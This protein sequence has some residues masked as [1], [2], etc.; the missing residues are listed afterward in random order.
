[1]IVRVVVA[2]NSYNGPDL[3]FCKIQCTEDE[4]NEGK[5]YD[6]AILA[7]MENGYEGPM[8]AIDE[9][10]DPKPLFTLFEWDTA[11]TYDLVGNEITCPNQ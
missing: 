5:H 10:D 9:F 7:A 3:Y 11:S 6:A 1:M 4:Y 8:V 2:G